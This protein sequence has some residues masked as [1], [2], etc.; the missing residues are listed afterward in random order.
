MVNAMLVPIGDTVPLP[1]TTP[2]G[3]GK[4]VA[5]TKAWDSMFGQ[6]TGKAL[7]GEARK[8][9]WLTFSLKTVPQERKFGK[10]VL[11]VFKKQGK[12]I[13]AAVEQHGAKGLN[14]VDPY[15][16][17][18]FFTMVQAE[19][20]GM[21]ARTQDWL[22]E[23]LGNGEDYIEAT[24]SV[25]FSFGMQAAEDFLAQWNLA[26]KLDPKIFRSWIDK[27]Q[28]QVSKY[29]DETTGA[30]VRTLLAKASAEG[31]GVPDM[32][33]AVQGYFDN[34]AYRAE[35]VA[36]TEVI[37]TNNYATVEEYKENGG[38]W[39][40]W[41]ATQDKLTRDDHAEAD[42]QMVA[43]DEPFDVGGEQLEYPG[44][45]AG[46]AANVCNCRCTWLPVID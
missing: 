43:I 37:G 4:A 3:Q 7:T 45:V 31:Q 9:Y 28:V 5:S 39:K 29:L 15:E 41:L 18:D 23:A 19:V 26:N 25:Y 16:G 22:D 38:K 17:M 40:Q 12:R 32:V 8:A 20:L 27:R 14:A 44:D 6:P 35:R 21:K 2:G 24:K 30:D 36:R 1:D 10:E 11:G 34:I 33:A 46:S 42:G 13:V